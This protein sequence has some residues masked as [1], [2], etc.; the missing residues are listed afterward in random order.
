MIRYLDA[1]A[2]RTALPMRRAI[3]AMIDAF[4]EDRETP[5]R[6]LL[7]QSLFMPGRA[8]PYT[9]IKVVSTTPGDPAGIVGVFDPDGH[10]IGIV[11]GATL[12]AIRTGAASGLATRLL[13]RDNASTMAMLGAGTMATDQIEAVRTVRPI[14]RVYIWSRNPH[15]A[16]TLAERVG[17][18]PVVDPDEAVAKADI[19]TTAT[20]STRPLFRDS[21]LRDQVHINAVGAF[22]PD[23]VEIPAPTVTR[24]FVVVDDI[25]AASAEAGDL[26]QAERSPDATVGDLLAGA[27]R[28]TST[29]TLFKSVGIA[30]QDIAAAV[31][32][33]AADS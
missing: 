8:G 3:D 4:S 16:K 6:I 2:L 30:S 21:S 26:I 25:D 13:A 12:T 1:A 31:A 14:E 23:M 20:P 17:G 5:Q 33:L 15:R 29:V 11:D 9:G 27:S 18:I 10:L 28:P 22:T 24:A 19:I 7:G 32:A